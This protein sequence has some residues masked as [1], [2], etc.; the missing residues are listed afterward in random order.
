MLSPSNMDSQHMCYSMHI[1]KSLPDMEKDY[2]AEI[3]WPDFIALYRQRNQDA[4]YFTIP[5]GMDDQLVA[6]AGPEAKEIAALCAEFKKSETQRIH[7]EVAD[8]EGEM[9]MLRDM[10]QRKFTKKN[11]S[12]LGVLQRKRDKL[13]APKQSSIEHEGYRIYPGYVAPVIIQRG[14]RRV[15]V[16]MRYRVLPAHGN[17]LPSKFNVFNARR[18]KLRERDTWLPLFG[19]THGILPFTRFHEWVEHNGETK[20]V[21]FQPRGFSRMH[22][23]CL[24]AE[25]HHPTL[26]IIRS[27]AAITDPAPPEV[28]S[29]G[30]DRCPIFL[31]YDCVDAWLNPQGKSLEKLD[32]LLA[33][34][35]PVYFEHGFVNQE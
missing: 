1:S 14:P 20:Q 16:P 29:A 18:D 33:Q 21:Y 7:Q 9:Q 8:I 23:A 25:Y 19:K 6:Q 2:G 24:Y 11:E 30:H 32:A 17:E 3:S 28:D 15:I 35:D 12:R 22:A 10:Q 4:S 13:L 27:C 34:K 31:A 26:G 5:D